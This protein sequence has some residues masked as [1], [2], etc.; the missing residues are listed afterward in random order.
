MAAMELAT[1]AGTSAGA[2]VDEDPEELDDAT[3]ETYNR[4][5]RLALVK[6]TVKKIKSKGKGKAAKKCYECVSTDHIGANCQF[7]ADRLAK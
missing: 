3:L 2:A 4:D 5:P 7:K 1:Y 6:T